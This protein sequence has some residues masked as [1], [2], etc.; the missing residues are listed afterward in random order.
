MNTSCTPSARAPTSSTSRIFRLVSS[1]SPAGSQR[2]AIR[3]ARDTIC[4]SSSK[5]LPIKSAV[6]SVTPVMLPPGRARLVTIP[7]PTGS[8]TNVTTMGMVVV[9]CF[10]A[11]AAGVDAVTMTSTLSLTRSAAKADSRSWRPD[12]QRYSTAIFLPSTQLS[13]RNPRKRSIKIGLGP[14][15]SDRTPIRAVFVGSW[16]STANGA[17]RMLPPTTLR[18]ARRSITG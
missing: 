14:A 8:A 6:L 1:G 13:S 12:A 16:A 11:R 18:N 9:A 17:V 10:A 2:T 7:L 15:A 3:S 4:V 5:Y